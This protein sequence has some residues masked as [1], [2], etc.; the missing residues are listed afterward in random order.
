[1][2]THTL[3]I[4]LNYTRRKCIYIYIYIYMCIYVH[5][6]MLTRLALRRSLAGTAYT[7]AAAPHASL[8][9]PVLFIYNVN[10]HL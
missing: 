2:Y 8:P 6:C 7:D 4:L 3:L 5:V 9:R 1:M 10:C